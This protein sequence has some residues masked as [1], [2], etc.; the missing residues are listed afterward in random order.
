MIVQTSL[1][2]SGDRYGTTDILLLLRFE[3]LKVSDGVDSGLIISHI[4]LHTVYYDT[5][6]LFSSTKLWIYDKDKRK[7]FGVIISYKSAMDSN[8]FIFESSGPKILHS[9]VRQDQVAY[10]Y[11]QAV[12]H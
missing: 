11:V 1:D 9:Q 3:D 8:T 2:V 6:D 7:R 10:M 12:A 4:G 5:R